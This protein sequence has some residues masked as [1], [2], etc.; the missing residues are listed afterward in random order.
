MLISLNN[1]IADTNDWGRYFDY[2]EVDEIVDKAIAGANNVNEHLIDAL[3]EKIMILEK[4]TNNYEYNISILKQK[5]SL[6]LQANKIK[7][8]MRNNGFLFGGM[9]IGIGGTIGIVA[10][11]DSVNFP[12]F[13]IKF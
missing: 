9:A 13:N 8:G 12:L 10:L 6:E 5:H 7:Y 11:V 1:L 3:Q 2:S 4:V